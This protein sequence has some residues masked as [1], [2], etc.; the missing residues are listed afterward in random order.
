V[1][2]VTHWTGRT[3]G[4]P[5]GRE[6]LRHFYFRDKGT[7]RLLHIHVD[8]SGQFSLNK[9]TSEYY[10]IVNGTVNSFAQIG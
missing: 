3:V 5:I 10:I 8:E 9:E 6:I 4:L 2:K 7:M 1:I